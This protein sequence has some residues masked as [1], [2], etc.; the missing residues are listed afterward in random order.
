MNFNDQAWEM[1]SSI[2]TCMFITN[3]STGLRARPMAALVR[4]EQTVIWFLTDSESAKQDE[5]ENNPEICLAF[6]D[7][8][9]RFV[10]MTGH[11]TLTGDR[12]AIR[13]IWSP[14]AKAFWPKGPDDPSIVAIHVE[15]RQGE[16]WDGS[17]GLAATA[18]MAFAILTGSKPDLGTS[19]KVTL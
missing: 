17:T 8:A 5:I 6:S 4:P 7:G 19:A 14:A 13:D 9:S 3:A 2:G 16:I 11:A 15:P 10:S 18:K 12:A 1:M